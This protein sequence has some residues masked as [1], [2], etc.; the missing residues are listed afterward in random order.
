VYSGYT[1]THGGEGQL[2]TNTLT[3]WRIKIHNQ[4]PSFQVMCHFH[5]S[6]ERQ[7]PFSLVSKQCRGGVICSPQQDRETRLCLLVDPLKV[8]L[9][10]RLHLAVLEPEG[11]LLLGVLD[12]VAAV[13]HVA[14]DVLSSHISTERS[15][16]V[17]RGRARYRGTYNSVVATDG[18]RGGRER[19][20]STEDG[21]AGLDGV[22]ALPDH[23]GD[24]AGAHVR[25]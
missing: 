8:G 25:N 21:A 4:Y 7:Y 11:N 24:G 23:G 6:I 9:L 22:T 14:A 15:E 19:V 17:R 18:A 3:G 20:G 5:D 2:G 12:A 10:P 1:G 16:D 13:A